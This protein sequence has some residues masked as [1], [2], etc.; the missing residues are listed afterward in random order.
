MALT[1]TRKGEILGLRWAWVDLQ[2]Q[3]L[4]LPDSKTGRKTI[5]LSA[6]AAAVLSR[7]P[8]VGDNPF[9]FAGERAGQAYSGIDKL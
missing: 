6:P 8:R 7:L 9:V 5:H 3:A 4:F 1:G 2:R